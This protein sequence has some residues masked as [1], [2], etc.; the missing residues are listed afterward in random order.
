M[1]G[2][3]ELALI[4]A[5]E[6][7]KHDIQIITA[8]EPKILPNINNSLL[9]KIL[10]VPGLVMSHLD[11]GHKIRELRHVDAVI[12]FGFSTEFLF[13]AFLSS[14]FWTKNVYLLIHHN[15]QQADQ[16]PIM[17]FLLRIYHSLGYKFIVNEDSSIL[18][19]LGYTQHEVNQHLSLL[20]PVFEANCSTI[21]D[22][23]QVNK[24]KV[25]I[26]GKIRAGKQFSQ[27][28][29]LLLKIQRSSD[30]LLV[31]GTDDFSCF[32][33]L[34][35]Q[36]A[37]L[38]NTSSHDDYLS[39]LSFCDI[40]VLNY[41]KSKY[42]YR[43]SGVAADA[44]STQ[45]YVVCPDYPLISHQVKYPA[46]VGVLYKD[47]LDLENAL[48]QALDLTVKSETGAFE[49]HYLERSPEKIASVLDQAIQANAELS[50]SQN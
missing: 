9:R 22:T 11:L 49:R 36:G 44:I 16:N 50:T 32:D 34:D 46:Q 26:I 27:T 20:H 29:D 39:A 4:K 7:S 18:K 24:K 37:K 1:A 17:R 35:L 12:V 6:F 28:L 48:K 21:I 30:I 3:L 38:I 2:N 15:I 10:K 14:F 33:N 42:F 19:D 43:C 47:E 31:F 41:E 23:D 40:V 45:T 8:N 13:F 5:A 25:G